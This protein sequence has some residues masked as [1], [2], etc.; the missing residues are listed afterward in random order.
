[1]NTV[2]KFLQKQKLVKIKCKMQKNEC[3]YN[4]KI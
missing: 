3:F 4:S 2:V 1:M